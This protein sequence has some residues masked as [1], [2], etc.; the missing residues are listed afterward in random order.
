MASDD[1]LNYSCDQFLLFGDSIVERSVAQNSGGLSMQAALAEK[2][3]RRLDIVNR[4]FNGYNTRQA[5][6]I[7]PHVVPDPRIQRVRLMII[8]FGAND[9]GHGVPYKEPG[10]HV[11][12]DEYRDNLSKIITHPSLKPHQPRLILITPPPLEERLMAQRVIDSG[13][14]PMVWTNAQTKTYADAVLDVAKDLDIP[15]LD[16]FTILLKKAGWKIGQPFP[17]AADQPVN[18]LMRRLVIDGIHISAEAYRILEEGLMQLVRHNWPDLLPDALPFA[19][20]NW[21]DKIWSRDE[22]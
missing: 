1:C 22:L 10:L 17:G 5:L 8:L 13:L 20:P 15:S 14:E 4:G 2:Y 7:L 6:K 18:E 16:L 21:D 19:F 9:A 11:P 12:L 3:I